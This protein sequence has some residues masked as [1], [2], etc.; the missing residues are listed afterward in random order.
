MKFEYL[1]ELSQ[2]FYTNE[3][4]LQNSIDLVEWAADIVSNIKSEKP[5]SASTSVISRMSKGTK[6]SHGKQ[7]TINESAGRVQL[8]STSDIFEVKSE[9]GTEYD[10][11]QSSFIC[12]EKQIG[13][14]IVFALNFF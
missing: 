1:I 13:I 8:T 2:W 7:I 10:V 6:K 3:Y 12:K 9:N 14:C 5:L 11:L 4:K